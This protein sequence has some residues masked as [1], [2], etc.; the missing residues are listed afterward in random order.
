[1]T[2]CARKQLFSQIRK[3]KRNTVFTPPYIICY[4][5]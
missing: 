3:I 5:E 4:D 2:F 1:M